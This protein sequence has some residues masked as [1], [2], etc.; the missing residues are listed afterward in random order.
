MP[1]LSAQGLEGLRSCIR[2]EYIGLPAEELE[3]IIQ[4]SISELSAGTAE[5]FMST[6]GS[7]GKAVAPALERA[8]PS[9]AAGAA[10]GSTFGPWGTLI[11]AGA[12]LASSL[13]SKDKPAPR[14]APAAAPAAAPTVTSAP[15][16]AA[17]PPATALA[18][19]P[20]PSATPT[21]DPAQASAPSPKASDPAPA[22]TMSPMP[23]PLSLPAGQGA[24]ATLLSLIQ[25]PTVQQA[26]LSQV[27]GSSG[28]QQ[29]QTATGTNLPRGAIN[30]LL[31]HLLANASEA[32]PEA[33]SISEQSYLR[34]ASGNYRVDPA[35][36]EQQA[37][38]VLSH[39]EGTRSRKFRSDFDDFM[40]G[41]EWEAASEADSEGWHDMDMT[42]EAV[43]FY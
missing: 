36:L 4:N 31:T 10:T 7:L 29:V 11:G 42:S 16:G 22:P 8:A 5:D 38:L 1:Q 9:V 20:S 27:L 30:S 26:L 23:S 39:L 13:L 25:N 40:D 21:A 3:R 19:A 43:S 15:S 12:G 18:P 2:A 34:D 33:E 6:L 37:A 14:P 24:A 41:G 35:S 32:L 17:P 28:N